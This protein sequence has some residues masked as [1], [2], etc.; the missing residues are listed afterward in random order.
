MLPEVRREAAMDNWVN[1]PSRRTSVLM[2][3]AAQQ[4]FESKGLVMTSYNRT[5]SKADVAAMREDIRVMYEATQAALKEAKIK[6]VVLY[7][8]EAIKP[9]VSG[10]PGVL[11]SWTSNKKMAAEFAV[12]SSKRYP[13]AAPNVDEV[14]VPAN[15]VLLYKDGP[16]WSD[17]RF[18][19]QDE[20]VRI[21][22]G[23]S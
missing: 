1:G 21:A 18:G 9:G 13:G 12:R 2:K 3:L 15:E 4:E 8:G 7:R 16:G 17:G 23:K 5:F 6:E 20:F 10:E 19:N 11:E 22:K 14:T